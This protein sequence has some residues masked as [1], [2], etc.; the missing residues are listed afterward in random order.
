MSVEYNFEN[1]LN[2]LYNASINYDVSD[3]DRNESL[4]IYNNLHAY[5]CGLLHWRDTALQLS[6]N[7]GE[8]EADAERLAVEYEAAMQEIG[9]VWWEVAGESSPALIAHKNRIE[10]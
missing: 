8:A 10:K 6:K 2:T 3:Y 9:G 5:I 7:H 1:D 4:R